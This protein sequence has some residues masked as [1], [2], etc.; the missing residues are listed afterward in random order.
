MNIAIISMFN[1]PCLSNGLE[2]HDDSL[3]EKLEEGKEFTSQFDPD[4]DGVI[5]KYEELMEYIVSK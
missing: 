2:E 3:K 4:S 1:K 5:K